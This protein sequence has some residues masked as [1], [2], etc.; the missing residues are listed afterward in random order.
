M[1]LSSILMILVSVALSAGSQIILKYAMTAPS[2]R[3]ALDSG[4]A[5]KN[6]ADVT[7][8]S[9]SPEAVR[10]QTVQAECYSIEPGVLEWAGELFEQSAIARH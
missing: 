9:N 4:N 8:A 10:A 1:S 5:A 3:R 7:I 2:M 6:G